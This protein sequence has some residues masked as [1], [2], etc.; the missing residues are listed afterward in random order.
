M[1]A[2]ARALVWLLWVLLYTMALHE[3]AFGQEPPPATEK[4][5][6]QSSEA[7]RSLAFEPS[8]TDVARIASS[9]SINFEGLRVRDIQ[10]RGA[11]PGDLERLR[12]LLPLRVNEPLTRNKLRQ[13]I[14]ALFQ[15][16]KFADLKVEAERAPN[17]EVTLVF[18]ARENYFIG[19]I[20]I[21]NPPEAPPTYNQLAT[22]TRLQLGELF[23]TEKLE[24]AIRRMKNTLRDNGYYRAEITPELKKYAD[25][26]QVD[27]NFHIVA[28]EQ[29]RVGQV[30]VQGNPGHTLKEIQDIAKLEPG[31]RVNSA[32]VTRALERLRKRYQKKQRLEAQVSLI[33][34]VYHPETN[35]VDY[36]FRIEHGPT[37]D[38]HVEGASIRKGLLK[39]Y[40]PVYEEGAVDDDLLNEGRRNL[41]DYFQTKGYFE[42][43]I[44]FSQ[45]QEGDHLHVIYDVNRGEKHKLVAIDI[46]GN[47]FFD[48]QSIREW[49]KIQ[50]AGVLLRQGLFSQS[51]LSSDVETIEGQYRNN[52][53]QKVSIT[54]EVQDDYRGEK[55]DIRVLLQIN[56]GPKTLVASVAIEGNQAFSNE[57]IR[58]NINTKEDQ[59][60][61]EST[62]AADRDAV[63]V[64]YFN[65]GFPNAQLEYF[66]KERSSDPPLMDVVYKINEG[67]QVFTDRVVITGLN[68]TKP[69]VVTRELEIHDDEP[70]NQKAMLDSQSKL[71]DL[72]IFNEVD[73]A[74]QNPEGK[75][76]SKNV[77]LQLQESRRYTFNYGA[78]IEIQ[79]GGIS[80][81][82]QP[83]GGTSVSPRVS[84]DV[85]RLNFLGRDHTI[86]LKTRAGR[87]QQRALLSYEVP[88]FLNRPNWKFTTTAFYD[89]TRDVRTFTAHRLEGSVQAEQRLS[90]AT[91]LLYRFTYRRVSVDPDTLAIDP[92]LIP[93]LSRPVRVGMP[94]LTF[95][96]DKRDDPIDSHRGSY[97]TLDMGVSADIFGSEASFSRVLFTNSTYHQWQGK[98]WVLARTARIGVE[99][100]FGSS[101]I[102]PLPERFFAGGANSHRGFAINQAGP[103]DLETGF[104]VGGE[105]TF[106]H[107]TELR[108]E[109]LVLPFIGDNLSPVLFHDMGNVFTSA[110]QIF[111]S[112]AKLSQ[113]SKQQC[114]TVPATNCDFNYMSHALGLGFRYATPIGPVRVDFGYNLNPPTFPINREGRFDTLRCFNFYFS[115]GQTF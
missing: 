6:P 21:T 90:K 46:E 42:V 51:M 37:V 44:E 110:G 115:I 31:D 100:P 13:S 19:N 89:T 81:T 101:T 18:V 35:L 27:I 57:E 52:G 84:F 45:K 64:E 25:I 5:V 109:P 87:L 104:P 61:A 86:T 85:T 77:L 67:S 32:G 9:P 80:G 112:F 72:G 60:F 71:Y 28:G 36:V 43:Q 74:V 68:H 3:P 40:V 16:G 62:L 10:F 97:N 22:S 107:M 108:L 94:A 15:T 34:R 55:G 111:R 58:E 41:R 1:T 93:L 99:G 79:S 78:G 73:I 76:P 38:I 8:A 66:V 59:A 106:I 83:Q 49:L 17:A 39:K 20:S 2:A 113:E 54:T 69:W 75:A 30:I 114:Q 50:P 63:L 82:D 91:T 47:R 11:P 96:R 29:A 14:Q 95:I 48:D 98:K 105:A 56:E 26:Q 23:T 65:R 7:E 53:F 12:S 102:I 33:D 24:R 70:L 92:N 4:T 88:W 103:R